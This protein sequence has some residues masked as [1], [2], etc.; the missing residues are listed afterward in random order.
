MPLVF[1]SYAHA[2]PAEAEL[3]RLIA[4]RLRRDGAEL[5][6]DERLRAGQDWNEEIERALD[7][8]DV[9]CPLL[10]ATSLA[11]PMI[12]NEIARVGERRRRHGTPEI[13]PIR[14]RHNGRLPYDIGA[15]LRRIQYLTWQGEADTA[16]ALDEVL[17]LWRDL[18]DG[19]QPEPPPPKLCTLPGRIADF[20]GRE[21]EIADLIAALCREDRRA[22]VS[23]IGGM[24]GAGKTTLA[25]EAAWRMAGR[26]PDGILYIDMLGFGTAP[27]LTREQAIAAIIEQLE[28]TAKLPDR[29]DQLLP[30]YRRLLAGRKLLLLLDNARESAQVVDLVPPSPVALLVTSRHQIF[31]DGAA[32]LDL[33]VMRAGEAHALLRGMI[34]NRRATDAELELLADRCGRLPLALRAAGA[35]LQFRPG[36]KVA[37]YLSLL[38]EECRRLDHLRVAQAARDVRATLKLSASLLEAEEPDLWQRWRMLVVFPAAFR[39]DAA[40]AI[41]DDT[42]AG[43][44]EAM[45]HLVARSLLAFEHETGRY[46]LHDL[47][48][49]AAG[50]ALELEALAVASRRHAQ[51]YFAVLSRA[52]SLFRSGSDKALVGLA[53]FDEE[54]VNISAGRR[55]ASANVS[56]DVTATRLTF[57]YTDTGSCV[58]E[59]RLAVREWIVWLEDAVAACRSLGDRGAE[60]SALGNL[61]LAWAD[62]GETDRAVSLHENHLTIAREIGDRRAEASALGN[63]ANA[64]ADLGKTDRAIELYEQAL[65]TARETGDRR[66]EGSALGN[67]G[68]VRA[69]VGETDRAIE[70]FEQHRAIAR[71][72]DDRRGEAS[73]LGNLGMIR[74]AIGE[75]LEAIEPLQQCLKISR[76]IGD[77]RAANTALWN[78]ARAY[79]ALGDRHAA[80]RCAQESL[81]LKR[82]IEDPFASKVEA[83]LR[84]RAH[85]VGDPP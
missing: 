28:P 65:A 29:L 39:P 56:L 73:A 47:V 31:L 30:L 61:G 37:E 26:F 21:P 58:L 54:R 42:E 4:E 81:A 36:L 13:W 59:L 18:R 25:I 10:S 60:G 82:Q 7:R 63:L 77:R 14:C 43:A 9:F 27:P 66:S 57:D 67:L 50:E 20:T 34:D 83:W 41:W 1:V 62:L 5:F 44:A 35:Y 8:C 84:A 32:R 19:P 49:V 78:L 85:V 76:E 33:D 71:E 17:G 51:H 11:S 72:L 48:R 45:A 68:T 80:L 64:A 3:A 22:A 24:G 40:A 6:F 12:Q 53:L 52:D 38:A 69:S 15:H 70:H 16:F 2:E 23:A 46:R 55:W 74:A 79:E 75:T